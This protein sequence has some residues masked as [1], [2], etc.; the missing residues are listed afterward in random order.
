M[1]QH[2]VGPYDF[3]EI[4][5]KNL[6]LSVSISFLISTPAFS[7]VPSQDMDKTA[8]I[9]LSDQDIEKILDAGEAGLK[10]VKVVHRQQEQK[11]HAQST[12][13][14]Y[15]DALLLYRHKR[16]ALA[17]DALVNVEDSI[18]DY[19]AT[20]RILRLIDN[21]SLQ[22]LKLEEHRIK[23]IQTVPLVIGFSQEASMLYQRASD[24]GDD[25]DFVVLRKKMI[26]VIQALKELK[27]KQEKMSNRA[28]TELDTQNQVDRISEK[29]DNFDQEVAK[30]IKAKNYAAAQAKFDEFQNAMAYDLKNVKS[31]VKS[32]GGWPGHRPEKKASR[33][34]DENGYKRLENNFF[35]QGITLY[36]T[37][38]YEAA[39]IIFNELAYQ[40]NRE[41]QAYLR[42]T[43]RLIQEERLK[44]ARGK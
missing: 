19:K 40:G 39:W 32:R 7:S 4:M 28:A 23:E 42:K 29:A 8:V 24:L 35:R 27:Q 11:Q 16:S 1:G 31:A 22:K 14:A 6:L 37:K 21:Q 25:Q 30:L 36:R 10:K 38:N 41:A 3:S 20:H 12:E 34:F 33:V 44:E 26:K 17:R 15:Q 2:K 13:K 9:H 5:H 18:A 43:T